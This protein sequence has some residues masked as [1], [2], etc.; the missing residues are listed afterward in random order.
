M[1]VQF[2]P[3]VVISIFAFVTALLVIF[4]VAQRRQFQMARP[5]LLLVATASFWLLTSTLELAAVDLSAKIFWAK[6]QYFSIC[7]LPVVW[8]LFALDYTGS[9]RF[10]LER[11]RWLLV[12]PL[13]VI[14]VAWTNEWHHLLWSSIRPLEDGAFVFA[15]FERG[16]LYL[17]NVGYAYLLLV[18]GTWLLIR[19]SL[20]TAR[21]YRA[22]TSMLVAAAIIPWLGNAIYMSGWGPTAFLDLTP[23]AFSLSSLCLV[24]ALAQYRLVEIT[25]VNPISILDSMSDGVVVLDRTDCIVSLN[26]QAALLLGIA[27]SA[28]VGQPAA[29]LLP[30]LPTQ[31]NRNSTTSSAGEVARTVTLPRQGWDCAVEMRVLP[32]QTGREQTAGWVVVLRDVTEQE[33]ARLNLRRSEA[34]NQALL[35]AIPDQMFLMDANGVYLEFKAAWAEDLPAPPDEL[36]GQSVRDIFSPELA[37]SILAAIGA[38]LETGDVQMLSYALERENGV[39][40]FDSRFVAYSDEAVVATVRNVTERREAD[41][42]LQEQRAFLRTIVDTLPEPIFIKDGEGR[43]HFAN[44]PLLDAFQMPL[45]AV[46]GKRDDDFV[47]F[48]GDK[49]SYYRLADE[50]VLK[51]GQDVLLAEDRVVDAA[52][53]ERFFQAVKRRIFSPIANEYQVLTV[54]TDSTERRRAEE[55]LRLQSAALNS[56]ANA[57]LISDVDGIIQWVNPAFSQLTGYSSEETI[58]QNTSNFHS[59]MQSGNL[60]NELWTTIRAG[61]PW[62]GELIN[63]RK[64]G[65]LYIEEMSVTPV[66]DASQQVT[67]F[68][69]IKQDVTQRNRDADR[70]ARQASEFRTQVEVGRVLHEATDVQ[71]LLTSVIQTILAIDEVELQQSAAVFLRSDTDDDLHLAASQGA[72]TEAY[73]AEYSQVR[74]H[75]GMTGRSFQTGKVHTVHACTNLGCINGFTDGLTPHGH[76]LIPLKS[77]AQVLGVILLYTELDVTISSW[78]AR[79]LALFE[80]IGGQ[81]GLTLD[82]LQQEVALREA[83]KSAESANRAKSEFLANMSHEIRTPM[84]AVIGMTSLL[85]D[86]PLNPEQQEFVETVRNS[87]DALLTLINDILDFSKIESGHMELEAHPFNLQECIEDVLDLLAPNAAKKRLELAYVNEGDA[88]HTI[89][90]D[91]TRLRQILVNL[92]GNGI[93]F[94]DEG[95]I[96]VSL[97]S[98]KLADNRYLLHFAVRDT[99]IGIPADGINRLFRS[100]SQVDASTT[101]RFGGSGLGL[102]ISRRLVELMGGEM[103]VESLP[104]HGSTFFFSI[105]AKAAASEKRIYGQGNPAL[106]LQKRLLIVDDNQTNRE[107][108]IRQSHAWGMA[109]VAVDSGQAALEL[110]AEDS[111]FD[112]AVLDMQMPE[113][114]GLDLARALRRAPQTAELALLMLTSLG[115]HELRQQSEELGFAGVMTKPVKRAQLFEAFIAIFSQAQR[116]RQPET[117]ESAFRTSEAAKLE[118]NLRILLAEDNAVNQKVAL[119]TLERLG[120]RADA[121]SDGLE[122]LASLQRQVYDVVLM[123][124]QMPEMDGLEATIHLRRELPANRQP[125]IIAMTANAMQGDRERCLEAG[126]DAY[127]SKPFKVEELV[128]ALQNSRILQGEVT[129]QPPH[130]TPPQIGEGTVTTPPPIWGRLG[131]GEQEKLVEPTEQVV[132]V[133]RLNGNGYA[134]RSNGQNG[135]AGRRLGGPKKQDK[136]TKTVTPAPTTQR[137]SQ[138]S[139]PILPINWDRLAQLKDDLGEESGSFLGELIHDFLADTPTHLSTLERAVDE[140]NFELMH[141]SAHTLKSTTGML[142]ADYLSSLCAV[143]EEQTAANEEEGNSQPEYPSDDWLRAHVQRIVYEYSRVDAALSTAELSKTESQ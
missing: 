127:L 24:I 33:R 119:R 139:A 25:P 43:Y 3:E 87:G 100:F 68:I 88:P 32:L 95:E 83:K 66:L 71:G 124:V 44:Q 110:L 12:E 84:N 17:V 142:G 123:D 65:D 52:G 42:R 49:A 62:Q 101:R 28:G 85:L 59:G 114:D 80:V 89:V 122:V 107:I 61:K 7:L 97:T 38:A 58:G 93:K 115:H 140:R 82:R 99:G 15:A 108:L 104:G 20:R 135:K 109:P 46:L 69:A 103:R 13:L 141:R 79:R 2:P 51:S 129:T 73:L 137:Q 19:F 96:V 116:A 47:L 86:T 117:T 125:Y 11:W 63:R 76:V 5:L 72:F 8:F 9:S 138:M 57:I 40:Y 45:E 4:F 131:G 10:F 130:P 21:L 136:Q 35:E 77:G 81:I 14:G 70:L 143:L 41:E 60:Y 53:N 111:R 29:D 106:L 6:M 27:P 132:T 128:A 118:P 105:T 112:L 48:A 134:A 56:A 23:I 98:E 16:P 126:M 102:V 30:G 92:V 64:N 37:E 120:Y 74:A 36:L 26:S 133:A 22:Q 113:M 39:R 54:A 121:V 55:K 34:K 50:Q 90:G 78:D 18:A 94:T 91:V 75:I 31:G 67:H 1:N